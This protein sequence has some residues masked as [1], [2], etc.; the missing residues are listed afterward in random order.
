MVCSHS[1]NTHTQDRLFCVC[2]HLT[3]ETVPQCLH[4]GQ[5]WQVENMWANVD[6]KKS[7]WLSFSLWIPMTKWYLDPVRPY[8]CS[9]GSNIRILPSGSFSLC[10]LKMIKILVK[11]LDKALGQQYSFHWSLEWTDTNIRDVLECL[12]C[13][14]F[15]EPL[16]DNCWKRSINNS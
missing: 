15:W 7:F 1:L 11:A 8:F 14:Q 2:F 6:C 12:Q 16:K 3:P 10:E 9:Q 5:F 4:R 13:S